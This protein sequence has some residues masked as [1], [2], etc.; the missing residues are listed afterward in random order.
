ERVVARGLPEYPDGLAIPY[1]APAGAP[2][3]PDDCRVRSAAVVPLRARGRTLGALTLGFGPSGRRHE[4]A[5]LALAADLA[6][7]AAIAL[8]N[9]RLYKEVEHADRQKNEF[10]SML[11]H[12]LRN[13]LAPIRN[14]AEVFRLAAPE[15]PR[16]RW[17]RE[18]IDRQLNHLVRL[19]DDLL[20]VSR[21]TRGKIRLQRGPVDLGDVV[22]LAVEAS[23]PVIEKF[24]HRL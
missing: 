13:P 23:R 18:V 6:S 15:H 14:A 5:D 3:I 17:A 7:R 9:A 20:D 12:E 1:P 10:L 22:R 8:D 24:N 21:I 16:L 11:A 4:P 19:V 2:P